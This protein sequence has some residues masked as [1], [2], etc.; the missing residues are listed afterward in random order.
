[1]HYTIAYQPSR[2]TAH[3]RILNHGPNAPLPPRFAIA[4]HELL[5]QT[6]ARIPQDHWLFGA[7]GSGDIM[8]RANLEHMWE[9][10]GRGSAHMVTA[11]GSISCAEDP[12][13]QEL[14][15]QRLLYA[16]TLFALGALQ[17]G[18]GF[19]LKVGALRFAECRGFTCA[20]G[21]GPDSDQRTLWT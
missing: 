15:V 12:N 1:M 20:L 21:L 9:A 17:E 13:E 18:R 7:D 19:V 8:R 5:C 10:L 2:N 3:P 11:D 16:E 14:T 6:T 4:C